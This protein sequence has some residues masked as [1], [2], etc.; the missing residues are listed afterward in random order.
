M[1]Q[2]KGFLDRLRQQNKLTKQNERLGFLQQNEGL[3]EEELESVLEEEESQ[4]IAAQEFQHLA[5]GNVQLN[6]MRTLFE[7]MR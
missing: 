7:H 4:V 2:G 6:K 5:K 1:I 3:Q